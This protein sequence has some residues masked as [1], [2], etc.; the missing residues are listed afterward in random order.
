MNECCKE[1][2]RQFGLPAIAWDEEEHPQANVRDENGIA[3]L[4]DYDVH[5]Y[6]DEAWR[7]WR[8]A[9]HPGM[10]IGGRGEGTSEEADDE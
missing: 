6:K 9:G 4:C 8:P 5:A 1:T 10:H 2:L 7:C 3:D